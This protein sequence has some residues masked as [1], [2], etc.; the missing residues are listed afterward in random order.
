MRPDSAGL[1]CMRYTLI[2]FWRPK[3]SL[4]SAQLCTDRMR[5]PHAKL[6]WAAHSDLRLAVA[7]PTA[8][9]V[10]VQAC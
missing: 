5:L 4:T 10:C 8:C 9:L 2:A 7:S 1:L 6:L 3:L